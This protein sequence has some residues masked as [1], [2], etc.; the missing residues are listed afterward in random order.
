[1]SLMI[2][3]VVFL[4]ISTTSAFDS[5]QTN[6]TLNSTANKIK[7]SSL[8]ENA[9]ME[10][11]PQSCSGVCGQ[12]FALW[13]SCDE[14][15][16]IYGRC[17]FDYESVCKE[18]S[19]KSKQDHENLMNV[20]IVCDNNISGYDVPQQIITSC[21]LTNVSANTVGLCE[22]EEIRASVVITKVM[23]K[24]TELHYKNR[25]CMLCNGE[26][27][28]DIVYW[29]TLVGSNNRKL[30]HSSIQSILKL[31]N[32]SVKNTPPPNSREIICFPNMISSCVSSA[33]EEEQDSCVENAISPIRYR[34]SIY[35][36][37]FCL[38]CSVDFETIKQD[39]CQPGQRNDIFYGNYEHSF[40]F[41]MVFNWRKNR[42]SFVILDSPMS[43]IQNLSCSFDADQNLKECKVRKCVGTL[44][45]VNNTCQMIPDHFGCIQYVFKINFTVPSESSSD[46]K[47][48][49][50]RISSK[51]VQLA[52]NFERMHNVTKYYSQNVT[53][54]NITIVDNKITGIIILNRMA[55]SLCN[56][57]FSRLTN[58][59]YNIYL[60]TNLTFDLNGS[61]ST[62][63][64]RVTC[65]YWCNNDD[66]SIT[67]VMIYQ[68]F[69]TGIKEMDIHMTSSV[70]NCTPICIYIYVV[71]WMGIVI[72]QL[73]RI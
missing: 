57:Q 36:N 56:S 72:S 3:V 23:S 71:S 10:F 8:I 60:D 31:F 30:R 18:E 47:Q 52:S 4:V 51:L 35:K 59:Q 38:Q 45:V 63:R 2:F 61:I 15:C 62:Q 46:M 50:E 64:Y 5:P 49:V 33:T 58:S 40:T 26:D 42:E 1:M 22:E 39:I 48:E 11:K 44:P 54:Y 73:G 27:E 29:S 9:C 28:D 32:S 24:R 21:S 55:Y 6:S 41:S 43:L 69:F 25:H 19:E 68:R 12:F 53:L 66:V 70:T 14:Y 34:T 13:C 20:T 7:D 17:C 16:L 65:Y 67:D 37:T